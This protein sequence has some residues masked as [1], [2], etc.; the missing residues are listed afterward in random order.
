MNGLRFNW[1]WGGI[2]M[3]ALT[4]SLPG[5]K[6][7]GLNGFVRRTDAQPTLVQLHDWQTN[8]NW[9]IAWNGTGAG[10][11]QNQKAERYTY[12]SFRVSQ[13]NTSLTG[14]PGPASMK[15]NLKPRFTSVQAIKKYTA[16]P[17]YYNTKGT[18]S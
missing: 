11:F 15:M 2:N 14:G 9:Y 10:M 3:G 5:V 4:Q 6:G 7:G 16:R 8:D 13:V 12:P 1:S 18:K 17:S